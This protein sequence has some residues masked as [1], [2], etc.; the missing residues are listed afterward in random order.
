MKHYL[1]ENSELKNIV[2]GIGGA[3][4][5]PLHKN[6]GTE[7]NV[8]FMGSGRVRYVA[9]DAI[10][11]KSFE[12]AGFK[13]DVLLPRNWQIT[14][15]YKSLGSDNIVYYDMPDY[16]FES[17]AKALLS[18][19]G[20]IQSVMDLEYNGVRCGKYALASMMRVRRV[21][22]IDLNNEKIRADLSVAL[23]ASVKASMA[24]KILSVH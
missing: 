21:G 15:A 3:L 9:Q 7:K 13:C 24:A 12:L 11:R 18:K 4:T 2:D 1:K 23:A 19:C 20:S 6:D 22:T 8:L 16:D 17:E 5:V 10:I 14:K